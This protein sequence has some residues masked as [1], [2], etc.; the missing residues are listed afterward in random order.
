MGSSGVKKRKPTRTLPPVG[1]PANHEY[2]VSQ[3]KR[4]VFRGWPMVL[5]AVLLIAVLVGVLALTI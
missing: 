4:E 3:H 2:E 5:V 1:S